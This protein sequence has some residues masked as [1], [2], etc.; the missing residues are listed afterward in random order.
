MRLALLLIGSSL[1]GALGQSTSG[2]SNSTT[3]Q[4]ILEHIKDVVPG[5]VNSTVCW[6]DTY[7]R[8]VGIPINACDPGFDKDGLLCYPSCK[9][10]FYGVGPVCWAYCQDGFTDEGALCGKAGFITSSDNSNCP[11]YDKCGLVEAK[12]CSTCP[13]IPGVDVHNDGCT[14]RVDPQVYAKDSYG[15]GAGVPL[16]CGS[17]QY[18]T[19]LC[20][21]YCQAGFDNVGPVCWHVCPQ[22]VSFQEGALCCESST[23][24]DDKVDELAK[25]VLS[26]LAAAI[27]AG[28]DLASILAALKAAIDAALGFILPLCSDFPLDSNTVQ[29]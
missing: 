24:C 10:G 6:R 8:G 26:A 22:T 7:G 21:P 25:A 14:C 2:F 12:G 20:Y 13:S 23:G 1:L 17:Q 3:I 18:D 28:G 16:G 9:P 11:W 4:D 29:I 19:G 5:D 27:E 15:R